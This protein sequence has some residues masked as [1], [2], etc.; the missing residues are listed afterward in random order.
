[1]WAPSQDNRT[2][3]WAYPGDGHPNE[4]SSVNA[5]FENI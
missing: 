4:S 3:G 1:L 2:P 5:I